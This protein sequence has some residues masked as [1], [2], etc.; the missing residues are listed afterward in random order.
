M[1]KELAKNCLTGVY[2]QL[3]LFFLFFVIYVFGILTYFTK[4]NEN[5]DGDEENYEE[6]NDDKNSLEIDNGNENKNENKT[7]SIDIDFQEFRTL[8]KSFFTITLIL[9]ITVR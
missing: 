4:K 6:G 9:A 1:R 7:I 5:W 8:L 3:L 2:C